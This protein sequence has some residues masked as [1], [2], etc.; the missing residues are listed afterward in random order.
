MPFIK[1]SSLPTDIDK[2]AIMKKL[3]KELYDDELLPKDMATC[4][5]NTSDCI[6]HSQTD[7]KI[8]EPKEG[9]FSD[10]IFVDL[11]LNTIINEDGIGKI[12]KKIWSVLGEEAAINKDHIF[13][14]V[15]LGTPGRVLINNKIWTGGD[16]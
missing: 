4:I 7:Y 10:L 9:S 8:L 2:A 11:Y 3:E 15:H 13:I 6:V 14:H 5:W 12:M 16:L 1:I